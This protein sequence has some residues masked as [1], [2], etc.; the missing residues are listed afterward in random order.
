MTPAEIDQIKTQAANADFVAH[1]RVYIPMLL[2]KVERLTKERDARPDEAQVAQMAVA[3]RAVNVSRAFEM[4]GF[5]AASF[6]E[7]Q[8]RAK[9]LTAE[10]AKLAAWQCIHTDGKTG[11]VG[12]E[13]GHQICAKDAQIGT[14][15]ARLERLEAQLQ[16]FA[17]QKLVEEMDAEALALAD[18]RSAYDM[19]IY[20]SR[21]ALEA[22]HE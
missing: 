6:Q 15:T 11:I 17:E 14:L 5:D 21:A 22:S 2:A 1:A 16:Q 9:R 18:F 3:F 19:F 13:H 10:N 8:E 4:A 7:A 20:A 12:T